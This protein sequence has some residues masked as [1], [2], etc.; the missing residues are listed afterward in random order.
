VPVSTT[1]LPPEAL[2]KGY[3]IGIPAMFSELDDIQR[4]VCAA[5]KDQTVQP[6]EVIVA[7]SGVPLDAKLPFINA[8]LIISRGRQ[9]KP[10]GWARNQI[11]YK[12]HCE[13]ILFHDADDAMYPDRLEITRQALK[14][15][16]RLQILGHG[17]TKT[18]FPL[19]HPD[20]EWKWIS[21]EYIWLKLNGRIKP[22]YQFVV[23]HGHIA[24]KTGLVRKYRYDEKRRGQDVRFFWNT[25]ADL[26]DTTAVT[27][28][29]MPLSAY[30]SR[31]DKVAK[32]NDS[33]KSSVRVPIPVVFKSSC[34]T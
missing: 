18:L 30:I 26:N 10:A 15:W 5:W 12:T 13:W 14:M 31:K 24:V 11:A 22:N 7:I 9:L 32:A 28:L 16:P 2:T 27:I 23:H 3:A 29:T 4:A 21:G 20:R 25:L 8:T 19:A 6:D 34:S 17:Y 33:S 1:A